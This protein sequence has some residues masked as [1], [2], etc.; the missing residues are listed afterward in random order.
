METDRTVEDLETPLKEFIAT[1]VLLLEDS[2]GLT[3]RTRLVGGA[4]DSLGLMQ[5]VYFI[6][7]RFGVKVDDTE[8]TPGNFRR[9]PDIVRFVR[10][11]IEETQ[12]SARPPGR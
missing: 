9:L 8:V 2:S 4:I 10:G 7:E 1:Q 11:K 6:Q 3:N 12:G 5:L